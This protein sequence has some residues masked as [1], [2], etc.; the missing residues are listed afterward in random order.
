M[1]INNV[2]VVGGGTA[3]LVTALIIKKSLPKVSVS[4]IESSNIGIIGVGEGS[5]E[6]WRWFMDACGI[7]LAEL[8]VK[9]R[10]T[11]KN[12][13]RFIDW[14]KHTPDYFHSVSSAQTN[15][16]YNIFGLYNKLISDGK[17]L[18]ESIAPQ[19]L[20]ED[21]VP[22]PN[23]HNSVNQYHF[24]TFALNEYLHFL[25]VQ[26]NIS[27]I[28]GDVLDVC[29]SETGD[30]ESLS[31]SD[32]RIVSA[33]LWIDASG[34]SRLLMTKLGQSKWVS[35]AQYLQMN[36]AIAFPTPSDESG[37]IHPY[38]IA[39]A[40]GN[41]WMWE[42]PTQDRRGNGYVYCSDF[43]TE[44]QAVEEASLVKNVK[45][46]SYRAFKFDPGYLDKMWV[47][48]CIAVGLASSFFEP[49]EAT[50]I[51]STIQQARAIV[52]NLSGYEK[53]S[54]SIQK[55]Y[56]QKMDTMIQNIVSMIAL[57]YISDRDDSEMWARQKT[58]PIPE[59]LSEL[60]E[61]WKVRP[62]INSDIPVSGYEMFM[63]PHFYHVVQGQKLFNPSASDRVLSIFGLEQEVHNEY[64]NVAIARVS[65][66]KLDHAESLRQ[67]QI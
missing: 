37:K 15:T 47:R 57:H 46:D 19:A 28:E 42:I 3:G 23:P 21:A 48:N 8:I 64:M 1:H 34:M 30:I 36:A 61:L 55:F 32:N 45:V 17:T 62:P 41:G 33:D 12:G 58:K 51:G 65:Q 11:H 35:V 29:L 5:T 63:V 2:V 66:G 13:I 20:I 44:E 38:T 6:H 18:T 9:T 22:L 67:I 10:A 50:S 25:C 60:L 59:Y 26:A 56:N 31:I 14:T 39:K 43:M 16:R 53:G 4:I 52:E 49:I 7:P 54:N 24:D 40:T 27:I